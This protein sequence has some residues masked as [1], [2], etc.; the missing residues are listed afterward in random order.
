MKLS[1]SVITKNGTDPLLTKRITLQDGR[2]VSDATECKMTNGVAN[3]VD[4]ALEALPY[5]LQQLGHHQAITSGWVNDDHTDEHQI[6][7]RAKFQ[8]RSWQLPVHRQGD[9]SY[10]TRTLDSMH[11]KGLSLLPIDYDYN[12]EAPINSPEELVQKLEAVIPG[13]SQ[14]AHVVSY[15]SSSGIYHAETGECLKPAKS[16][17]LFFAMVDGDDL[18]RIRDVLNKR[19]SL[20]GLGRITLSRSGAKLERHLIDCAVFSPERLL[21]E[22]DPVLGE[23]LVQRRPVPSYHAGLPALDT[24]TLIPDLSDDEIKAYDKWKKT[25]ENSPELQAR[26][27]AIRESRIEKLMTE[28]H[29][30]QEAQVMVEHRMAGKL[31]LTDELLFDGLDEPVTVFEA[32]MNPMK[33]DRLSLADPLEPEKGPSKAMFYSNDDTNQPMIHTFVRGGGIYNLMEAHLLQVQ[34]TASNAEA[35]A[36]IVQ[37]MHGDDSVTMVEQQY[38][39]NAPEIQG[40]TRTGTVT[41]RSPKGTGKTEWLKDQIGLWGRTIIVVHRTT[42]AEQMATRLGV[43]C[44]N[45]KRPATDFHNAPAL[46]T[47]YDSLHKFMLEGLPHTTVVIDEFEQVV[48]HIKAGTVKRKSTALNFF[49]GAL[50]QAERRVFLDA[51]L[52]PA[53]VDFLCKIGLKAGEVHHYINRWKRVAPATITE[54]EG[55]GVAEAKL[56]EL[57]QDPTRGMYLACQAREKSR[58]LAWLVLQTLGVVSEPKEKGYKLQFETPLPDGRRMILVNQDTVSEDAAKPFLTDANRFLKPTDILIGSPSMGTGFS[59]DAVEGKPL[60]PVRFLF[61]SASAGPTSADAMQHLERVRE[62][63]L[64]ENY[65]TVTESNKVLP[66]DPNKLIISELLAAALLGE[67][68]FHEISKYQDLSLTYNPTTGRTE[69][70]HQAYELAY[71]YLTGRNHTDRNNFSDNLRNRLKLEGYE[72]LS[73][74]GSSE[75]ESCLEQV[76]EA[77]ETYKENEEQ[78][79][80]AYPLIDDDTMAK[81]QEQEQLTGEEKEMVAKKRIADLFGF[82]TVEEANEVYLL[83]DAKRRYRQNGLKFGLTL[84]RALLLDMERLTRPGRERWEGAIQTE[85]VD[86]LEDFMGKLGL[87]WEG[88]RIVSNGRTWDP[89]QMASLYNW[90]YKVDNGLSPEG[91]RFS[92]IKTVLGFSMPAIEDTKKIAQSVATVLKAAGLG[93]FRV[94]RVRTD[95]GFI[96]VR[97]IDPECLDALNEDLA[98]ARAHSKSPYYRQD[99]TLAPDCPLMTYSL[100]KLQGQDVTGSPV[101]KM[102][103]RLQEY[104]HPILNKELNRQLDMVYPG[105]RNAHLPVTG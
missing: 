81:L 14:Y 85:V 31:M 87:S 9:I 2:A 25:Q 68:K 24:K 45:E 37:E 41:V 69:I 98:R 92:I 65:L 39:G 21:F 12:D 56:V 59:I 52:D 70:M 54:L 84:N 48:E 86:F 89:D 79:K 105:I 17:H 76:K 11:Q 63:H 103:G 62:G 15:S 91:H 74:E 66:T 49:I 95:D 78:L 33:Y 80:A 93:T 61:A 5:L 88:D 29:S 72:L 6:I 55:K 46:V 42:L 60:F 7:A 53:T 47:T 13:L 30:R 43:A 32:M 73:G 83:S 27:Q 34:L 38:L 77:K 44:Y 96:R 94:S 26:I 4:I 16:F 35:S 71:G 22:A 23:G 20:A 19:L 51:D 36:A 90:L 99:Y 8:D 64:C 102:V 101:H 40:C 82:E 50:N 1:L 18:T 57:L 3:R 67:K 28:G 97:S 10:A 104:L 100:A 58:T 75:L